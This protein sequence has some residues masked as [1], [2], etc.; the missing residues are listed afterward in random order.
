MDPRADLDGCGKSR[1]PQ[2][3]SPR[4]V[5]PVAGRYTDW[6]IP[7]ARSVKNT[8]TDFISAL[9]SL[10]FTLSSPKLF[11]YYTQI[12]CV[13]HGEHTPSQR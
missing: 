6:A 10:V 1:S 7:A 5:Q 3:F 11:N 8:A 4:T 13:P 2:G 12:R 9:H